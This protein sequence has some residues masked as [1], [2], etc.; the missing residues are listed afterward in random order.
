MDVVGIRIEVK[1]IRLDDTAKG[2]NVDNE[3]E[4]LGPLNIWRLGGK[5]EST[6]KV[7]EKSLVGK[8]LAWNWK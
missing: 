4:A 1:I 6:K 2:I 8:S 7:V 3:D 5:G